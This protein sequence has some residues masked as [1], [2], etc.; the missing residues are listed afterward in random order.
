MKHLFGGSKDFSG[1]RARAIAGG[2]ALCGA[3][4]VPWVHAR[5]I[6]FVTC[7]ACLRACLAAREQVLADAQRRVDEL[8]AY[9]RVLKE[10]PMGGTL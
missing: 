9:M 3:R 1:N 4:G 10:P 6:R 5:Y 8:K 7:E 2:W